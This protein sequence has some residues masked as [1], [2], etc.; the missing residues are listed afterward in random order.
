M[1]DFLVYLIVE[2]PRFLLRASAPAHLR[3][4]AATCGSTTRRRMTLRMTPRHDP[5]D[6]ND[7][8]DDTSYFR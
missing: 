6:D 7:M 1:N 5:C 3:Q 4:S 8:H 2:T